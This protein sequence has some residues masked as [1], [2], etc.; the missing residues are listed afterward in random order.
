MHC[1]ITGDAIAGGADYRV[2][3]YPGVAHSFTIPDAAEFA[4]RFG[5]PLRYDAAADADSWRTML[6]AFETAFR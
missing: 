1:A 2:V 5:L 3:D 4:Q 6:D